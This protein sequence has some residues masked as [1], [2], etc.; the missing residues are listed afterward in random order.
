[1]LVAPPAHADGHVRPPDITIPAGP[2]DLASVLAPGAGHLKRAVGLVFSYGIPT[3]E[4]IVGDWDGNGTV[5]PGV[6]RGNQ[7]LLRNSATGG[8]ATISFAFGGIGDLPVT[9]EWR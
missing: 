7:W 2:T 6:V 5:T 4:P 3:D 9:G 1:M 8:S